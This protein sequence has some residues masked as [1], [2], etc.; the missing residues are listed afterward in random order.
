MRMFKKYLLT[1]LLL[2]AAVFGMSAQDIAKEV[3]GRYVGTLTVNLFGNNEHN[4]GQSIELKRIDETHVKFAIYN[5]KF[6]GNPVG[7]IVIPS[8]PIKKD[9]KGEVRFERIDS[10]LITLAEGAIKAKVLIQPETSRIFGSKMSVDVGVV[11]DNEGTS[12]DIPVHFDGEKGADPGVP[13]MTKEIVGDYMGNLHI[14]LNGLKNDVKA[15]KVTLERVADNVVKFALYDF[16]MDPKTLI[17]D[18]VL[19]KVPIVKGQDGKIRFGVNEPVELMLKNGIKA[20]AKI[21]EETSF[22]EGKRLYA[23]VDVIWINE[24]AKTPIVTVFDGTK[25]EGETPKPVPVGAVFQIPNY[26]FETPWLDPNEPG[27]GWNSFVSA[28]ADE[29]GGLGNIAKNSSKANTKK[30]EGYNSSTAVKIVSTSIVGKKANGNLTTGRIHMGSS[31]PNDPKNFNYTDRSSDYNKLAF[32]GRPDKISFVAKYKRGEEGGYNG[33]IKAVLHDNIDFKDPSYGEEKELMEKHIIASAVVA[34]KPSENW[35]TYEEPMSYTDLKAD[36]MFMLVNMTTNPTPGATAGDELVMDDFKFIYLSELQSAKLGKASLQI[37]Q[38]GAV[39]ES[40]YAFD[41]SMLMLK[42]NGHGAEIKSTFDESAYELTVEVI[43]NDIAVNP[44]NKHIYKFK[45]NKTGKLPEPA[46]PNDEPGDEPQTTAVYQVPNFNFET[47]WVNPN[48]PGNG[49]NSFVSA[50]A[51]GLGGFIGGVAIRNAKGTTTKVEGY[52]SKTAV[53]LESIKKYGTNITGFLTTG[54][55]NMG[56]SKPANPANYNYTDFSSDDHNLFFAGRPDSVVFYAKFKSA[57]KEPHNAQFSAILHDRK[58]QYKYP[59]YG[60]EKDSLQKHVLSEIILDIKPSEDWVKYEQPLTYKDLKADSTYMLINLTTNPKFGATSGDVLIFDELRFVYNSELKNFLYDGEEIAIPKPGE[61]QEVKSVYSEDKVKLVSNAHAASIKTSYDNATGI[62]TVTV[63][64]NDYPKNK[65]NK[66]IYKFKFKKLKLNHAKFQLPNPGFE[67]TWDDVNEP[68]NGW[69]SFVSANT[70]GLGPLGAISKKNSVSNTEKVEGHNSKTAVLIMSKSVMGIAKANGNLTTGRINMGSPDPTNPI[71][72]NY[73]DR[74]TE[75]SLSFEGLPDSIAFFA[76]YSRGEEGDY[77]GQVKAILHGDINYQDPA[78]EKTMD[79]QAGFKF[80]EAV[81]KVSPSEDWKEY[82][83]PFD[84]TAN[85]PGEK[86]Y[87]L[88][89]A[90]TNPKPG[91]TAG[92]K[93]ALD[94]FRFIYSSTL[95]SFE[96]DGVSMPIS[97][98]DTIEVDKVYDAEKVGSI[99]LTGRGAHFETD[100]DRDLR[101][102]TIYVKGND[103]EVNNSNYHAYVYRFK[104]AEGVSDVVRDDRVVDVYTMNG[105]LLRKGISYREALKTLPS[106]IYIIGNEKVVVR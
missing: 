44:E 17:G 50:N 41:L 57:G 61:V 80:A 28:N 4:E 43:G 99:V 97:A 65:E 26:D 13:D 62:L 64:G 32:A 30:A 51:S 103:Y 98:T 74:G 52:K 88:I 71:N 47:E 87:M 92:D 18:I 53:K 91:A 23:D 79:A 15:S 105:I 16:R 94:D 76:K 49:W 106:G 10:T 9:E 38:N 5:F 56:S 85:K 40:E 100:F 3:S 102:F 48:E 66:H 81:A 78:D 82:I 25:S 90:T 69:Y 96:Y 1:F 83:V 2:S 42:S 73:T 7:D 104:E 34:V 27:H 36:S 84:Y 60:E 46:D 37:P 77:N 55:I 101:E 19:P 11:W 54:R 59:V 20:T 70:K 63:R 31:T 58:V 14:E 75:N 93:M 72:H 68:G 86:M 8:V 29:L 67:E 95:K 89:S 33:R 45:F 39:T 12:I 21:K 24:E 22:I 6:Q 35:V